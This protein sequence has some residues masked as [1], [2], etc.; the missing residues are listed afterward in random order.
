MA[1]Q[2]P[3]LS[4][5]FVALRL[6]L[7]PV[8]AGLWWL[9]RR[10]LWFLVTLIFIF[11]GPLA[12]IGDGILYAITNFIPALRSFSGAAGQVDL[13]GWQ[14]ALTSIG[15]GALMANCVIDLNTYVRIAA[16]MWIVMCAQVS[17][18]CV[19]FLYTILPGK[20]T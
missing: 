2:L 15:E 10:K 8:L 6:W 12:F 1:I 20:A 17:F 18:V 11:L 3:I 9:L 5:I 13:T 16:I 7:K 4:A 14:G 19:R